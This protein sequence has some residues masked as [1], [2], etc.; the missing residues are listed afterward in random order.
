MKSSKNDYIAGKAHQVKGTVK[1]VVGKTVN[2]PDMEVA[3]KVEK[4]EGKIQEKV[5][6]VEKVAGK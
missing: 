6:R 4:L 1:E 2:S 3:G 5:A